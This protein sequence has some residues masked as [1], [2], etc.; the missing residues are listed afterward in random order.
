MN[1]IKQRYGRGTLR[2]GNVTRNPN[3]RMRRE[4]ISQSF[5]TRIDQLWRVYCR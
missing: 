1:G 2:S 4:H 3:W 5:T